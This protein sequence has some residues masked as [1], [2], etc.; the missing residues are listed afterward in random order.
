M[1]DA[2]HRT[3]LILYALVGALLLV[4]A[5][6]A[7]VVGPSMT[8]D[9]AWGFLVL[10]SMTD[11]APFNQW[12]EPDPDDIAED[13]QTFQAAWAPGQYLLPA[14]A[15]RLGFTLGAATNVVTLIFSALGLL[16]WHRLYR[17]WGF[18]PLSC[19]MALA[20]IAGGKLFA[21]P[22]GIYNGGEVLLF[23]TLPWFTLLLWKARALRPAQAVAIGLGVVVLVFVKLSGLVFGLAALAAI[24]AP[25]LWPSPVVKMRRP[26]TA[27]AIALVVSGAFYVCWTSR[28][29]TAADVQGLHPER[30]LT[31]A[32][33]GVSAALTSMLSLG[34]LAARVFTG[35]NDPILPSLDPIYIAASVPAL[36]LL[37]FVSRRLRPSF[38]DYLRFALTLSAIYIAVLTIVYVVDGA[39]IVED[40]HYRPI[41]LVLLIGVVHVLAAV[42][43]PGRV[44][45][46]GVAA[47]SF[48]YGVAS[49]A[50]HLKEN[51]A[52]PRS[53]RGF[54]Y[55]NLSRPVLDFLKS[56]PSLVGPRSVVVVP[57]PELRLDLRH[58]RV[59]VGDQVQTWHGRVDRLTVVL[60]NKYLED[61][62][63]NWLLGAFVD[64]DQA[65]WVKHSFEDF[66]WFVQ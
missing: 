38:P 33:A 35:L 13:H 4:Y 16:G 37:F 66:T 6:G 50:N 15:E 25:D 49:Y 61:G 43:G 26:V 52:H 40:R 9:S 31:H 12:T 8:S 34:D 19:A 60:P 47:L 51:L 29:W 46:I 20:V 18:P 55:A 30:L 3:C 11:G 53:E 23:G 44:A 21:L 10:D 65:K 24:A 7:F 28:G 41:G 42:R 36:A 1:F 59:I 39:I 17:A 57:T 56:D 62:S 45:V 63:A 14:A 64:Y 54:R 5:A 58:A 32:A 2:T 48:T 27:F 22:F